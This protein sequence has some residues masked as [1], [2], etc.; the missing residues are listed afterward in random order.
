MKIKILVTQW[1]NQD[2]IE[3]TEEEYK[4]LL[5]WQKNYEYRDIE[6][7]IEEKHYLYMDTVSVEI[8][9]VEDEGK[10]Q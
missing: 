7:F 6:D 4:Q 8:N 9:V 1:S 10:E 5:E 3:V 2:T